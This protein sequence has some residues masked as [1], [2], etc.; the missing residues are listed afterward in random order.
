LAADCFQDNLAFLSSVY[1]DLIGLADRPHGMAF[2]EVCTPDNVTHKIDE[3]VR[4]VSRRQAETAKV[5]R[6]Y[7]KR[8]MP[9]W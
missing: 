3:G 5:G 4:G 8:A 7:T 9:V 6:T 1:D 2:L